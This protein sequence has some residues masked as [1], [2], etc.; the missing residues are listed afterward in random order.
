M[1]FI[2]FVSSL[3]ARTGQELVMEHIAEDARIDVKTAEEW[4]SLVKNTH[5]IKLLQPFSNNAVGRV[6]KRPKIYFMDTGLACY[7][8]GYENA[9]V[10]ERS[11][12]KGAIFETYIISEIIKSFTNNGKK[13]DKHLYYY[14]DNN[15]K[16]IDLL[17]LY[18]DT[19]YPVEIKLN[20]NPDTKAIKN[21]DIVEK[22]EYKRGS[23]VVICL[24]SEIVPLT[25]NDYLLPIEYV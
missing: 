22:V 9:T 24:T 6:T 20:S 18:Q 5:L 4:L 14:R 21:F 17:I 7:L 12:Y 10:L 11:A 23:G 16:E 25:K 13:I 1:A 15:G 19:I 8:V 3:A 2:R